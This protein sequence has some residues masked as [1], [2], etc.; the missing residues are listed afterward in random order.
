MKLLRDIFSN[1]SGSDDSDRIVSRAEVGNAHQCGNAEFRSPFSVYMPGQ[2]VNN[3]IYSSVV[4][5]GFKHSTR[6][7]SDDDQFTHS[8]NARSHSSEPIEESEAACS[9]TDCTTGEDTYYQD[10]HYVHSGYGR[11]QYD[12]V[13]NHFHP[14]DLL[15]LWRSSYRKSLKDIDTQYHQCG[16]H[17]DHGVYPELITHHAFL[18]LGRG[19][20]CVGDERKIISE[21]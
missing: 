6:Q 3:E 7:Q 5:D 21:E 9:D 2:F 18:C 4:A 16:R 20:G 1:R 15:Y 13:R 8:G 10:Q 19:N 11:S 12:K 17:Y 14:F